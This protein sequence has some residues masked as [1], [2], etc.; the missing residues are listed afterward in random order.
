MNV[1]VGVW[2]LCVSMCECVRVYMNCVR[3]CK[4]ESECECMSM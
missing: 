1:R 4:C 2:E 3:V